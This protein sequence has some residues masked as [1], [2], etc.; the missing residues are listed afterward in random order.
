[1]RG[2]T[3]GILALV[4]LGLGAFI[5][6]YERHQPT[7]EE[8]AE[9]ADK[10]FPAL[11]SDQ[12]DAV[13]V[14]APE[15]TVRLERSDDG[16]WRITTPIDFPADGSAVD[17]VLSALSDLEVD[18]SLPADEVDPA[19]YGLEEPS[20]TVR[21][22]TSGGEELDL[23]VG[24]ETPLGS[25]RA[26][27]RDDGD[28]LITSGYFVRDLDKPLDDWRS[29][30]VVD[31][32]A[33]DVASLDVVSDGEHISAV[34]SSDQW[35]L[36]QPV[37]DLADRDHL[38]N[39][40]ADLNGLRV[41]EFLP[42]DTD[43]A[44]LGLDQPDPVVTILREGDPNPVVLEFGAEREVD[45]KTEIACRRDHEDLFWVNDRAAVRLAKAPVRWRAAKLYPFD[46]WSARSLAIE[47]P[48][49]SIRMAQ[50]DGVWTLADGGEVDV[51]AVQSRL[52]ALAGLEAVDYD[53]LAPT[54][55]SLGT[56]ELGLERGF[57]DDATRST[58]TFSFFAP[59]ASGGNAAATVSARDTVMSVDPA[60]VQTVLGDL[61]ALRAPPASAASDD[62]SPASLQDGDE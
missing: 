14:T 21:V 60:A 29:R 26:V 23:A 6:F 22:H 3:L 32:T 16:T 15:S 30:D 33:A 5:F 55:P 39:L 24:D 50:E 4:V 45:S 20:I 56:V 49:G 13:D 48:S 10:V 52:G 53:L 61:D 46:T 47:T 7:T 54:T 62:A 35:R 11:E 40:V 31:V 42:P 27:R 44:E 36:L 8:A 12:V 17:S 9:R 58:V 37:D 34:H 28:V 43:L 38:Q 18:R 1:M 25:K 57:G 59:M 41:E 2:R 19:A 51:E